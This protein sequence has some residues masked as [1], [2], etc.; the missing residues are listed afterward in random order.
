MLPGCPHT[1]RSS[2]PRSCVGM[3][4]I[5]GEDGGGGDKKSKVHRWS[6]P[7][8]GVTPAAA[9]VHPGVVG[10][11]PETLRVGGYLGMGPG[12]RRGDTV[13]GVGLGGLRG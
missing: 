13:G 7:T 9:G 6:L 4:Q 3:G 5:V 8:R 12:L 2:R 11:Y 10:D 1:D